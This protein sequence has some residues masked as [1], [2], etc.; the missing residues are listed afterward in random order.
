M[1]RTWIMIIM[2]V[3]AGIYVLGKIHL[4]YQLVLVHG[5][6]GSGKVWHEKGFINTLSKD[7]SFEH[8]KTPSLY[9]D[10]KKKEGTDWKEDSRATIK[11]FG[12][13]LYNNHI[14]PADTESIIIAHSMGG[15]FAR[16][17]A[18][19][20]KA[21]KTENRKIK[22]IITMGTPHLGAPVANKLNWW[23]TCNV[24]NAL[25]HTPLLLDKYKETRWVR[26]AISG[27][28]V[29]IATIILAVF[30]AFLFKCEVK[31]NP[32]PII[33]TAADI[34]AKAS[35]ILAF[36]TLSC[37][38]ISVNVP[39]QGEQAAGGWSMVRLNLQELPAVSGDKLP[40]FYASIYGLD[41]D[42]FRLV[43]DHNID[44]D[45][46]MKTASA[47]F[48]SLYISVGTYH[49]VRSFFG[50]DRYRFLVGCTY[51]AC[52]VGMSPPLLSN[53][54]NI[55]IVNGFGNILNI[56]LKGMQSDGFIPVWSQIMPDNVVPK[57]IRDNGLYFKEPA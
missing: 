24:L 13:L 46:V 50:W 31:I 30:I 22:G 29:T 44:K 40:T 8:I 28:I 11:K 17:A 47:A 9:D 42:L 5:Y 53:L 37:F 52:G 27:I 7:F 10:W 14:K 55:G 54:Y 6:M 19:E 20:D 48:A 56:L 45:G 35:L 3:I 38:V 4:P 33:E 51:I 43:K 15:L 23:L 39:K 26:K 34:L 25:V 21:T 12:E 41:S 49:I 57:I 32:D 18:L 16:W 2:I 1:R 36:V